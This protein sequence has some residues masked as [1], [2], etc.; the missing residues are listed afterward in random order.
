MIRFQVMERDQAHLYQTL[1]KA[2]REGDLRT[3][4]VENRGRRVVHVRYPGRISW[5]HAQGV[6]DATVVSPK[7]QGNEWQIFSAL[8]GRLAQRYADS[9][10][11]IIVQFPE[12]EAQP[13]GRGRRKRPRRRAA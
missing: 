2:M 1:V 5:T 7:R 10:S 12:S 11:G 9:I 8:M 3:F 6:I 13:A 4:R